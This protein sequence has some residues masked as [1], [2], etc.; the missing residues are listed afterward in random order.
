M[1]DHHRPVYHFLPPANWLNDPNGLIQ[2][3][4]V[5][6]LFYQYTPDSPEPGLK[7]WGHAASRD[8]VHW[9]HLP[10]ALSPT[11]GSADQEGCWSGCAVVKDGQPV[12]IYTGIR[13]RAQL[14]CMAISQDAGLVEWAKHPNNPIIKKTPSGYDL[15]GFRDHSIW[16]EDGFWYMVIGS[17]IKGK[18]GATFLY[19]SPDLINWEY[20]NP[21]LLGN[22]SQ[23]EGLSTGTE[24]ECPEFYRLGDR[25]ILAIS[26]MD[27]IAG[28]WV[29]FYSMYFSGEYRDRHFIP[30]LR[31]KIDHGN[32]A[33][34]APQSMLD[35]QGR[36]LMWGWIMEERSQEACNRAGWAGV[37]SLP[38]QLSLD[39][40]TGELLSSPVP[41][42][43][44][45]RG[46]HTAIAPLRLKPGCPDEM[47]GLAGFA[48]EIKVSFSLGDADIFDLDL[49][50]A[51]TGEEYTRLRFDGVKKELRLERDHSSLSESARKEPRA[52]PLDA[53]GGQQ[54]VR[55]F[56]DHSVLE[57]C[58]N[59]CSYLTARIYPQ[60]PDSQGLR[61]NAVQGEAL[62][63]GIDIWKMENIWE[64]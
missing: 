13:D 18:G 45:L 34:Y 52:M 43:E 41:E 15:T 24:W 19:R 17:G 14:P 40:S 58:L 57:V 54:K 50:C 27:M 30:L 61:L 25:Y 48:L 35:E 51:P 28:K 60:R 62:I 10:I 59:E 6:H 44:A 21:L 26:V 20:L 55:V 7:Y 64:K 8:L 38:R 49:C 39:T 9:E 16:F 5:Y 33:F 36:R 63:H 3:Q 4:G 42:L 12:F 1:R 37:M 22:L 23:D 2:W 47:Q 32:A 53:A 29:P 56:L 11:P 31:G 46:K